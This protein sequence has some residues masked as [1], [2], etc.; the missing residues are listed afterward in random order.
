MAPMPNYTLCAQFEIKDENGKTITESCTTTIECHDLADAQ[1]QLDVQ[2]SEKIG[3][4]SSK[5]WYWTLTEKVI[6]RANDKRT[7]IF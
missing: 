3:H 4:F 7:F 1:K 2:I 6:K 5:G